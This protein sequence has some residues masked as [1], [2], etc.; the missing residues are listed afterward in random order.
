M[1]DSGHRVDGEEIAAPS[2]QAARDWALVLA[3]QEIG[4]RVERDAAGGPWRIRVAAADRDRAL[5][6]IRRARDDGLPA[7]QPAGPADPVRWL[8]PAA[9]GWALGLA[10]VHVACGREGHPWREFGVMSSE[11]VA[12]GELWRFATAVFLHADW[13]HLGAN[14]L[15]GF[16]LLGPALARWRF[17]TLM[18]AGLAAGIAGNAAGWWLHPRP[19]VALGASGM[20][21]GWLGWLSAGP[22]GSGRIRPARRALAGGVLLFVFLGAAPQGDI[23]AHGAGFLA[24]LLLGLAARAPFLPRACRSQDPG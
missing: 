14:L 10:L 3:S 13:L 17:R 24:G 23:V 21:L 8:R 6:Q 11:R 2:E 15:S 18:A 5:D 19:Y 7:A 16:L 22:S 20:I 4:C 9:V 1:P 12:R